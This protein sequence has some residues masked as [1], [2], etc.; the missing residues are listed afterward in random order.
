MSSRDCWSDPYDRVS[1]DGAQK[2]AHV[3]YRSFLSCK[4]DFFFFFFFFIIIIFLILIALNIDL[5]TC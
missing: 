3:L 2:H 5:S 4:I 1:C